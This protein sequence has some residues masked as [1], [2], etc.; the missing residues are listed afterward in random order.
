MR[1]ALLFERDQRDIAIATLGVMR[2]E[3]KAAVPLMCELRDADEKTCCGIP[4]GRWFAKRVEG[5]SDRRSM[6]LEPALRSGGMHE[7]SLGEACDKAGAK[8]MKNVDLNDDRVLMELSSQDL[9]FIVRF[10]ESGDV[11]SLAP[12][13]THGLITVQAGDYPNVVGEDAARWALMRGV[14]P[15]VVAT[16]T[17]AW[18]E[19]EEAHEPIV[20]HEAKCTERGF[21]ACFGEL[22]ALAVACAKEAVVAT[23]RDSD[24]MVGAL[25]D[26][27]PARPGK[28]AEP[29]AEVLE[30]WAGAA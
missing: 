23:M 4:V 11:L 29:L 12:L 25:L 20:R 7:L 5:K 17:P 16:R 27:P 13:A 14:K 30:A 6:A 8:L 15:S 18:V 1:I 10:T 21:D 19:Y 2:A 28:I 22:D 3:V 24:A 9:N 26:R